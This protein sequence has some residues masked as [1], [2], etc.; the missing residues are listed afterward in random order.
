[1]Y[2]FGLFSR[3]KPNMPNKKLMS[4]GFNNGFQ[5]RTTIGKRK[6]TFS[7]LGHSCSVCSPNQKARGSLLPPAPLSGVPELHST[8][9]SFGTTLVTLLNFKY[10]YH[11]QCRKQLSFFSNFPAGILG[12]N[13]GKQPIN[14]FLRLR[15]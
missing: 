4:P 1:M 11:R 6:S 3:F 15:I 5:D 7:Y 14:K 12:R 10:D 8:N 2:Y 13:L 9:M